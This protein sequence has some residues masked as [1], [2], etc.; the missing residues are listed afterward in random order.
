[1]IRNMSLAALDLRR[2]SGV[3]LGV[4]AGSWDYEILCFSPKFTVFLTFCL[5]VTFCVNSVE[6]NADGGHVRS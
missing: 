2:I 5:N 6:F 1:M 4:L 3:D